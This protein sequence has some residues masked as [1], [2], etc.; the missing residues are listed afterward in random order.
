MCVISVLPAMRIFVYVKKTITIG[1]GL[2]RAFK[3]TF[4]IADVIDAIIEAD[5]LEN[6][7]LAV[8]FQTFTIKE[9]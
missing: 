4:N 8:D 1:I 7:Q 9:L 2:R 5:F 6:F 3:W